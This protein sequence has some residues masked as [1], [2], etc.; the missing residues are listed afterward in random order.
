M[1]TYF[2]KKEEMG[3]FMSYR[4]EQRGKSFIRGARGGKSGQTFDEVVSKIL[5]EFKGEIVTDRSP[6]MRRIENLI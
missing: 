4:R 6:G 1:R 2:I 3:L 5:E